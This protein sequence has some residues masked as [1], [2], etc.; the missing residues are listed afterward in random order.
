MRII[1]VFQVED[2]ILVKNLLEQ[3]NNRKFNIEMEAKRVD[4]YGLYSRTN[5][6]MTTRLLPRPNQNQ[7]QDNQ[8]LSQL[9]LN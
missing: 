2:P 8:T 6:I 3:W 7:K 1:S 4:I 9:R 5:A